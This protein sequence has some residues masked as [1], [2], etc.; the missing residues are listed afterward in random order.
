MIIRTNTNIKNKDEI[1]FNEITSSLECL[2]GPLPESLTQRVRDKFSKGEIN[3]ALPK[4]IAVIRQKYN[5]FDPG[6]V[7]EGYSN[8]P[9]ENDTAI[10]YHPSDTMPHP[11]GVI[12]PS[13]LEELLD[14]WGAIESAV[15]VILEEISF[16]CGFC[17]CIANLVALNCERMLYEFIQAAA[18]I[19]QPLLEVIWKEVKDPGS[20]VE[21]KPLPAHLL[22]KL[23]MVMECAPDAS[24]EELFE[25]DGISM[26]LVEILTSR[27]REESDQGYLS[28]DDAFMDYV[29]AVY[30]SDYSESEAKVFASRLREVS[31]LMRKLGG[32]E[33]GG[34]G[35]NAA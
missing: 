28:S 18:L 26:E 35:G 11:L 23:W 5:D 27:I 34:G 30:P 14:N 17:R 15:Y 33:E 6:K 22:L 31:G 1:L 19:P 16:E 13:C 12:V 10:L 9:H 8:I 24:F 25:F 20:V 7:I 32:L 29:S 21:G 4:A 3:S 2:Y